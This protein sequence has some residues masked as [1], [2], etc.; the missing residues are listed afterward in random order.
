MRWP[1]ALALAAAGCTDAIELS[2]TSD[3]PA[4]ALDAICVGVADRSPRGGQFGHDYA[5][6][7]VGGLPQ[8]LRVEPGGAGAAWA[9]VRGDR[10]GVPAARAAVA[11]DFDRDV[12]LAMPACVQGGGGEPAQVGDAAGP[13]AARL[14][15]SQGQGGSLVVAL[16]DGS[17]AVID[18]DRGALVARDAP[19]LP[20][21]V[22]DAVAADVDGDCDDDVV[23]AFASAPPELWRRDGDAFVDAG[24]IGTDAVAA[25]AAGDVDG[26]GDTDL[27]VGAG[28]ALTVLAN[29]GGGGFTAVP[30]AIDVAGRVSAVSALA[31]GDV[32]GDGNPDLVV[33]QSGGSGALVAW[34]G[35][36]GGTFLAADGIVPPV[37]LDVA[38]LALADAD[39]DFDP[40]LAVAVRGA[41]CGSTSIA[42]ARSRTSRSC[43]CR[44]PRRPRTRSRSAAGTAAASP[45]R[46][47]RPTAARPRCTAR[48][49]ARSAATARSRRRPTS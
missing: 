48:P 18:A 10:G 24:A 25:I 33:G 23:I 22:V 14:V 8:T 36:T 30:G 34:L 13:A 11:I 41:P 39:G 19:A 35:E 12:A 17:A 43:G 21:A 31:L 40:D 27:V 29:D 16:G 3:R 9:W 2:I 15:A 4:T 32:D 7:V 28:G 6:P 37:P 45:T 5:L 46:S 42:T 1:I 44:S 49:T 38:R 47:S 20:D 26:D